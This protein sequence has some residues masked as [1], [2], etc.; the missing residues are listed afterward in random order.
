[1]CLAKVVGSI[2]WQLGDGEDPDKPRTAEKE[3]LDTVFRKANRLP[4][5]APKE[6]TFQKQEYNS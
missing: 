4:G 3:A 5:A 6:G 1:M 2:V